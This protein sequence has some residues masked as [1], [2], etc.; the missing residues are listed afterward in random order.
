MPGVGVSVRV[1][2]GP[3]R[4]VV[5]D[6]GLLVE[7]LVGGNGDPVTAGCDVPAVEVPVS[8]GGVPETWVAEAANGV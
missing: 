1:E 7:V 6:P 2:V 5:D 8:A 4:V 3:G